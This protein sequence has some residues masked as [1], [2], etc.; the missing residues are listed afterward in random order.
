VD[1]EG[2][3]K[4]LV[5]SEERMDELG[6]G[7]EYVPQWSLRCLAQETGIESKLS[8]RITSTEI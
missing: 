3:V 4:C 6:S 7:L 1:K 8:N 5:L 2:T